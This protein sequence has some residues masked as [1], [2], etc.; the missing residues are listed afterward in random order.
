[1][2]PTVE[3]ILYVILIVALSAFLLKLG[4]KIGE[5]LARRRNSKTLDFKSEFKRIIE[6][7]KRE[8]EKQNELN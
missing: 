7:W 1:M 8:M 5:H 2:D 3:T 6:E 4:E